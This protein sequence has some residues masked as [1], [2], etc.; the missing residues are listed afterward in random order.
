MKHCI[1]YAYATSTYARRLKR[2]ATGTYYVECNGHLTAHKTY[3]DAVASVASTKSKP[4]WDSLDHPANA[5]IAKHHA[6]KAA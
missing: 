3:A 2:A 4:A 5:D 1:G 6:N